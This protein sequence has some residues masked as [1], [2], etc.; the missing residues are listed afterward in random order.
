M[1]KRMNKKLSVWGVCIALVGFGYLPLSAETSEVPT[2]QLSKEEQERADAW[3][4]VED[5]IAYGEIVGGLACKTRHDLIMLLYSAY[6]MNMGTQMLIE[7]KK[8]G[9]CYQVTE[10]AAVEPVRLLR[11]PDGSP[12]L[13]V[14][15]KHGGKTSWATFLLSGGSGGTKGQEA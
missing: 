3:G 2:S 6:Y 14:K 15:L 7:V 12:M 11:K 8:K 4:S 13:I 9:V 5:G 10:P 1:K